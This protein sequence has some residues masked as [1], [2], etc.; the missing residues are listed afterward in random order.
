MSDAT[1]EPLQSAA[2]RRWRSRLLLRRGIVRILEDARLTVV[3]EAGDAND[4][5]A[6][7]HRPDIVVTDV[8]RMNSVQA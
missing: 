7:G 8:Q 3:V 2:C 5:L 6:L 1:H 4:L